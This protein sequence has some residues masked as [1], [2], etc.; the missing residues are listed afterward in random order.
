MRYWQDIQPGEAFT[1]A[2]LTVTEEDILEFAAEFD[3]Q[4]YHLDNSAAR[5]SIFGGLCASGWQVTAMMMRLLTD[6]LNQHEIATLGSSGVNRLR[7]KI[8]VFAGDTLSAR[9]EVTAC[10]EAE[11]PGLGR[12][13]CTVEVN[14]QHN[15]PVILSNITL[16]VQM[17]P[18]GRHAVSPQAGSSNGVGHG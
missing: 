15:K 7:W 10:G 13:E 9:M 3:P 18:D 1:T 16:L 2:E 8:P 6:T 17:Q 4:P 14:N 11:Q 12:L 5:E